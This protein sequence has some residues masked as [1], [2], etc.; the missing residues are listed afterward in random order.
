MAFAEQSNNRSSSGERLNFWHR[1][2][3]AIAER[4]LSGFGL[5]SFNQQYRRFDAGRGN[6]ITFGVKNPHQEF[7][8]WGVEAGVGAMLLLCA[9]LFGLY[10]DLCLGERPAVRAG[11]SAMAALLISCMFNSILFDAAIGD[12]FCVTIGLL[13]ALSLRTAPEPAPQGRAA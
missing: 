2:L 10:R 9:L 12:F 11:A 5:G 4:P 1:S 13:M 6:P 3:Q 8:L 7:L